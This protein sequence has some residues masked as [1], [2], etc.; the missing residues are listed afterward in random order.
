MN[1]GRLV[2]IEKPAHGERDQAHDGR[3][4]EQQ[5]DHDFEPYGKSELESHLL[6]LEFQVDHLRPKRHVA[7]RIHRLDDDQVDSGAKLQVEFE[8]TR[9]VGRNA[10][11]THEDAGPRFRPSR[12]PEAIVLR[13]RRRC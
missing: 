5:R 13:R 11:P 8:L 3:D 4:D 12:Q 9:L 6:H 7:R 10:L 1:V 2:L